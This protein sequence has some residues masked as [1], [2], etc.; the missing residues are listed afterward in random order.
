MLWH[1]ERCWPVNNT[2]RAARRSWGHIC[3]TDPDQDKCKRRLG[4]GKEGH[5]EVNQL[6]LQDKVYLGEITFNKVK[7]D[8][9]IA[10][11]LTKAVIAE[12]LGCH[13]DNSS[14]ECRRHR[15]WMAPE[16][17]ED[18]LDNDVQEDSPAERQ[19]LESV[20]SDRG[21][22]MSCRRDCSV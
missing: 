7:T 15:H 10:H 20:S 6:W 9:N 21:T 22:L 16:V 13:V 17:A 1:G 3:R 5:I 18:N 4:T 2:E 11:T 19:W 8:E 14:G 12:T